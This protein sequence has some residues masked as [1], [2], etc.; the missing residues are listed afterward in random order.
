M[1]AF[2]VHDFLCAVT[3]LSRNSLY[4]AT[5]KPMEYASVCF[6]VHVAC[7]KQAAEVE[8]HP[9]S[10]AHSLSRSVSDLMLG[11]S[12]QAVKAQLASCSAYTAL[13]A[14]EDPEVGA[15]DTHNRSRSAR[16]RRSSSRNRSISWVS[17]KRNEQEWCRRPQAT[18]L[19]SW[20]CFIHKKSNEYLFLVV[21]PTNRMWVSSP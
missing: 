8:R 15:P 20:E 10:P 6:I 21:H 9:S 14:P 1:L 13:E 7:P 16:R 4:A 3:P 5:P 19:T 11:V 12:V 18:S 2:Q 17:W